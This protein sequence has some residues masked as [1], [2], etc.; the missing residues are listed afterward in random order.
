MYEIS[1]KIKSYSLYDSKLAR[2]FESK[3]QVKTKITRHRVM[4][5]GCIWERISLMNPCG[6]SQSVFYQFLI[7]VPW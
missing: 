3:N 2:T 7:V 4:G 5:N 6:V 1:L